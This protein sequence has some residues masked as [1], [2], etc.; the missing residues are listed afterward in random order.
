[1]DLQQLKMLSKHKRRPITLHILA[2]GE[3]Q[4]LSHFQNN[5]YKSFMALVSFAGDHY[6]SLNL[7]LHEE[8]SN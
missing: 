8:Y 2:M 4:L 6:A 3:R 7:N 1:M 5:K